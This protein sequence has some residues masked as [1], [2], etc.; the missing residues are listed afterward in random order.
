M[1]STRGR[2][3]TTLKNQ[4]NM[5]NNHLSKIEAEIILLFYRI[6]RHLDRLLT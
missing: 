6:K 1:K 5:N 3:T 4:I 2:V